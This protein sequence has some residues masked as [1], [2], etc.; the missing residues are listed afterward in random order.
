[1]RNLSK[2]Y[3]R[4]A[5]LS[6]VSFSVRPGEILGL[7]GPNGSGKTTLFECLAG[8]LPSDGGAVFQ[9]DRPVGVAERSSI[10]FYLPDAIAP[11]PAESVRW[12]LEFIL[13]FFDG[14]A[15][16]RDDIV[17]R[18]DLEPFLDAS[19]GSATNTTE[20][21][22]NAAGPN[23]FHQLGEE[24]RGPSILDQRQRAV[25]FASYR[26]PT[27][28]HVTRDSYDVTVGTVTSLASARPFNATTGVDNNSDG[29]NN[30]RPVINGAVVSRYAFRGTAVYDTSVFGELRLHLAQTRAVTL[31]I[32]G[33][34]VFNR[35]NVLGRNGTYGDAAMP[36]ATFGQALGGL[37]NLDPARMVQFQVRFNF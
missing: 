22:G 3:G 35:A 28:G 25:I 6:D 4:L 1:V 23:D 14:R 21:N 7:I 19:I 8:V 13:G 20:P 26:L 30:D 33:F 2:R 17:R 5:A 15:A 31:R 37:A 9:H 18:F 16:A 12:A 29:V 36:L 11:W 24:E 27:P 34:N 32:E 10:L